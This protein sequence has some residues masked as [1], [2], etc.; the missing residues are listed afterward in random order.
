VRKGTECLDDVWS[1]HGFTILRVFSYCQE[2]TRTS[3]ASE[4]NLCV[5]RHE[6]NQWLTRYCSA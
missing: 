1:L 3:G 2:L 4:R 5:M 6:N